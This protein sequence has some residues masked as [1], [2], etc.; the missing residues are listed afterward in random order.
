M[1]SFHISFCP[2]C[3]IDSLYVMILFKIQDSGFRKYLFSI[4]TFQVCLHIS[5]CVSV[6][7]I[8]GGG[9]GGGNLKEVLR[10]TKVFM[11]NSPPP[12]AKK[13]KE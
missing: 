4:I 8:V 1:D 10:L 5:E 6:C 12:R 13:K 7:V 3:D 9:G 2:I 11:V